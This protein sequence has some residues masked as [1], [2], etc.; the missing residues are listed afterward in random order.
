MVDLMEIPQQALAEL[1]R[2]HG[3]RRLSLFGS[4]AR[5]EP[6]A[7]DIDL[8][9]DIAAPTPA[10]YA[11]AYLTLKEEL[12]DLFGKPVDLVAEGSLKNPHLR[13]RVEAERAVLFEA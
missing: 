9:V 7:R 6:N 10:V 8:L 2:R 5:G 4:A 11:D 3:V 1:C 13:R 12:E